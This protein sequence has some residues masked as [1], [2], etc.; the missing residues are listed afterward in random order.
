MIYLD[1]AATTPVDPRVLDAMM[2][3]YKLSYVG[4]PSSIH[5]HGKFAYKAI[6]EARENVAQL[7]NADASEIFFTSGG[8][9][10]N[11][12]WL[13]CIDKGSILTDRLEHHSVL[14]P[15]KQWPYGWCGVPVIYADNTNEGAVDLESIE[16]KLYYFHHANGGHISEIAA[17]SF[18]WVNNELGTINP[19]EEIGEICKKYGVP[20]HTDAVQAVGHTPIDVKKCN[21]D[22]LSMSGHK[23]GAPLGVG[24]LYISNRI[25]K[26]PLIIGG[27]QERGMRG[28]TPNVPA[29]VGLGKAAEIVTNSLSSSIWYYAT[30]RDTFLTELSDRLD[31]MIFFTN[32]WRA[33]RTDNIISLT[34]PGVNGE[35]LLMRL[36]MDGVCV[37]AGSA[38]SAGSGMVSHVLSA[39]GMSEADAACTIRISTG[40]TTTAGEMVIAARLIADAARKIKKIST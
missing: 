24:A 28:G 4:N 23:F 21:V 1:H 25:H 27:G 13:R 16:K 19:M 39:I 22:F 20:F 3:W 34:I 33:S 17:A 5:T 15:V 37:S 2:P 6:E 11:N 38:C 7:I 31:D 35:A 8:T 36:D 14:E 18:M 9:E 10:S 29:I 12:A 26:K 30:L 40:L 32:G